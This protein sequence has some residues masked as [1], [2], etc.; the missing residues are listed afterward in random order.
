M[1]E[2]IRDQDCAVALDGRMHPVMIS[3]WYGV[4]TVKVVDEFYRWSDRTSAAAMAAEQ[5]LIRIADL[6]HA[7]P[8]AGV[9]RKRAFEHNRND[10]AGEIT[11]VMFVVLDDPI[12]RS[13]VH[14][15]RLTAGGRWMPEIVVVDKLA[16]AIELTLERL[17]AERIPAPEGLDPLRYEPPRLVA[18]LA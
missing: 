5:R 6:S 10:L 7:R 12:F 11:L 1:I 16:T 2:W 18:S 17:H 4:A 14:T 13:I 15:L 9:V 8:P 3:S